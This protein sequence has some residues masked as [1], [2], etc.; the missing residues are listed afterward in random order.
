MDKMI[1]EGQNVSY[2]Q[3]TDKQSQ[4]VL[5]YGDTIMSVENRFKKG[6]VGAPHK[7]ADHEQVSYITKGSFE[8]ILGDERKILKQGDS[9]YAGK[10]MLHGVTAIEE[11]SVIIDIFTPIRQDFLS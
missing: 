1:V 8:I 7:H 5:S 2:K 4:R 3:I 6:G 11:D 9:F 10:N